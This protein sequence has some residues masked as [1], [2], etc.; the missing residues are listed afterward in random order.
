MRHQSLLCWQRQ[1][2][3]MRAPFGSPWPFCKTQS[4]NPI[5]SSAGIAKR[6]VTENIITSPDYRSSFLLVSTFYCGDLSRQTAGFFISTQ[7]FCICQRLWGF[8][9][10]LWVWKS[11]AS[12]PGH[13]QYCQG[14]HLSLIT[15]TSL[16]V[17]KDYSCSG[18]CWCVCSFRKHQLTQVKPQ[19]TFRFSLYWPLSLCYTFL[20]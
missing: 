16:W 18:W 7:H 14:L 1:A 5:K 3:W 17:K 10:D 8:F 12:S 2:G 13:W 20:N 6:P 4:V 15:Y 11:L 9:L 19:I